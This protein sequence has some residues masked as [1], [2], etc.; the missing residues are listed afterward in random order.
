M[1]P[2]FRNTY[3]FTTS[4]KTQNLSFKIDLIIYIRVAA[5]EGNIKGSIFGS[6]DFKNKMMI[7]S[8]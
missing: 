7:N 5:I 3:S 4:N 8:H 2:L 6:K 1:T